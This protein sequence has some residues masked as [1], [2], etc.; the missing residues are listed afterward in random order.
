MKSFEGSLVVVSHDRGFIGRIG[1][2]ILE[3][4]DGRAAL[5]PGS[6]DDYV[7]SLENGAFKTL[8]KQESTK[9]PESISTASDTLGSGGANYNAKKKLESRLRQ[10]EKL[11]SQHETKIAQLARQLSTV[12]DELALATEQ[13]P[14]KIAELVKIQAEIEQAEAE[15]LATTDEKERLLLDPL[16]RAK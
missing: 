13:S 7:W 14:E 11:V 3:I 15:W 12:N 2:K 8:K 4:S 9:K 1:T 10:L 6:Y 16:L 5:Y